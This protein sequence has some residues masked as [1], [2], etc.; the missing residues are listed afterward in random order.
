MH[1]EIVH[2]RFPSIAADSCAKF[3]YVTGFTLG[4]Y[5]TVCRNGAN[6]DI[7]EV[8]GKVEAIH[9][10]DRGGGGENHSRVADYSN[11]NRSAV[12]RRC[13]SCYPENV[14]WHVVVCI[15]VVLDYVVYIFNICLGYTPSVY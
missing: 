8:F 2:P 6:R 11:A 13:R 4:K 7:M 12:M 10:Y 1:Y 14:K 5:S 9:L 15:L 3:I